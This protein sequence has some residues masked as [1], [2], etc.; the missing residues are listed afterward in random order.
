MRLRKSNNLNQKIYIEKKKR[1]FFLVESKFSFNNRA[2]GK[3]IYRRYPEFQNY[4]EINY[5][6]RSSAAVEFAPKII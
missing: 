2:T 6:F 1:I 5:R 3:K 4:E